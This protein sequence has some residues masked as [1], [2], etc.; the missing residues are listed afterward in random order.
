ML[1]GREEMQVPDR[2]IKKVFVL[3]CK[4]WRA[5]IRKIRELDAFTPARV[6]GPVRTVMHSLDRMV[7]LLERYRRCEYRSFVLQEQ[8]YPVSC[9]PE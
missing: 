8:G 1:S 4:K 2:L 9:P 5:P 3:R 7:K 6:A